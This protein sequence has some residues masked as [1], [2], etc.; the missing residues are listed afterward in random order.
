MSPHPE[1]HTFDEIRLL[2]FDAELTYTFDG[3]VYGEQVIAIDLD[4]F[5]PVSLCLIQQIDTTV[6]FIHRSTQAIPVIF[7]DKDHGRVCG[8]VWEGAGAEYAIM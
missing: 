5:H 6:L 2:V 8:R 1:G 3:I 4:A 7:N